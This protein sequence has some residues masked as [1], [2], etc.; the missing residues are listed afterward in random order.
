M[1]R[2][3]GEGLYS[4]R[5]CS[6]CHKLFKVDNVNEW[7]YQT[8][9][10]YAPR[11]QCSFKCYDRSLTEQE[12]KVKKNARSTMFEERLSDRTTPLKNVPNSERVVLDRIQSKY[13]I[14]CWDR[15]DKEFLNDPDV[16]FVRCLTKSKL[17]YQTAR[18]YMSDEVK[19]LHDNGLTVKDI[20]YRTSLP[21][22][23]IKRMIKDLSKTGTTK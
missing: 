11:Y 16:Q 17:G 5:K 19:G 22:F 6:V 8:V 18:T 23:M 12:S 4:I 13:G 15:Q 14:D 2:Y 1:V 20:A 3:N 21:E 9:E 7:T 10:H